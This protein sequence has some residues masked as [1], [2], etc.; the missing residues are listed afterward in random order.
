MSH[1]ST[2]LLM[3]LLRDSIGIERAFMVLSVVVLAWAAGLALLHRW[4]FVR[5]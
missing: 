3:G 4:A 5:H 1:L 2:P